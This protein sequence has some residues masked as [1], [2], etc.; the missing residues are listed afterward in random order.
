MQ[1]DYSGPERRS[2]TEPGKLGRR[3]Y[4]WHCGEHQLIQESTRAHR[5]LVCGKIA[6]LRKEL[7]GV[8]SWKIVVLLVPV[9]VIILGAGFGYFAVQ[10]DRM[11]DRTEMSMIRIGATLDEIQ[12][13]QA[14]MKHQINTIRPCEH[15]GQT[16]E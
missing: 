15:P 2:E 3:G 16:P 4:D 12:Q 14:V 11:T 6:E 10:L 1:S 5:Q 8:V 13:S 9:A 7:G